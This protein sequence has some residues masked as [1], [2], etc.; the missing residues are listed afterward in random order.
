MQNTKIKKKIIL[1]DSVNSID[2]IKREITE[3]RN[4]RII[5]FD[6]DSH[7]NLLKNKIKHEISD[8]FLDENKLQQIQNESFNLTKWYDGTLKNSLEY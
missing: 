8:E 7:K 1:L 2:E 3:I 4:V 6:Y 5:T